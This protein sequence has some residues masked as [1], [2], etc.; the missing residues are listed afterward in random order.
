M[1]VDLLAGATYN[2]AVMPSPVPTILVFDSGL[3]GLT[4]FS[5]CLLYTSPS[6][7]DS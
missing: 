4:V 2:P 5:D 1:R 7:R 6:P 3:G